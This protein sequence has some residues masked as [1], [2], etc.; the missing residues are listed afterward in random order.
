VSSPVVRNI[1]NLIER[2]QLEYLH[3]DVKDNIKMHLKGYGGRVRIDDS[4]YA[5]EAGRC[6]H[7][8]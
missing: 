4:A 5:P 8:Y 7:S 2:D 1:R 3:A 6:K